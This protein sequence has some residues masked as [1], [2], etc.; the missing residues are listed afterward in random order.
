MNHLSHSEEK[1]KMTDIKTEF[2]KAKRALF[3]RIYR[4]LNK[5]QREAIYTVNGPLLVLAGAGSG[6]TTVLVRRISHLIKYGNAYYDDR[7]NQGSESE[8]DI[9]NS[10][11]KFAETEDIENMLTAYAVSPV[12]PWNILAI[13]F[14]NKAA[15]E[16]KTRLATTLGDEE[17]ASQIWAGTFHS[18]CVRILRRFG[19]RLGYTQ[20]FTIYD[21]D[22]VKKLIGSTMK[23]LNIS[24]KVLPVRSVMNEISRA[25]DELITPD[26]YNLKVG[27]DYRLLQISKIYT[28]YQT[29][30]KDA[31]AVDFDDII[32]QTVRLLEENS[33]VLDY[34]QN[35]FR[36]VCVDE[37]QDTNKAQF[38]LTSLLSGKYRNIMVVG[39]DDQSIYKFRGATIENILNF[40]KEYGEAKVIKLEQNY[41]STQTILDAANAV[42]R[43]NAGRKGKEL[44]TDGKKGEKILLRE[45]A[46]QNEEA[47]HIV[48]T[49]SEQVQSGLRQ[50]KDFVVLY[51]MNAQ[52]NSLESAFARGGVPYRVLGGTR[53]YDRK[54]IRDILAYL[55]IIK[56]PDDNL[57]LKRII[58]EPKRKIGDSTV[59][60]IEQLAM[61][62]GKSMFEIMR[63][64]S[65]FVSISRSADRLVAFVKM[66]DQLRELS[67]ELPINELITKTAEVSGYKDMLISEGNEGLDRISNI[68]ELSSSAVEY[69]ENYA[70]E[71]EA[72]LSG[73]LETV[74]LVSDVD[75]YDDTADAV[76]MM[77]IHSAKGL[78]FPVVFLPG[79]EENIFPGIQSQSDDAELEEERRLAYVAITRAKEQLYISHV[80]QR[81]LFGRTQMNPVSRF[82]EEIPAELINKAELPR[83]TVD[84]AAAS[85][86]AR[87]TKESAV[88]RFER[89]INSSDAVASVNRK[90]NTVARE[91]FSVGD[92]VKHLKFGCGEILSASNMGGDIM[93]EIAFDDFGT[94]K[95]M[96]SYAKLKRA[97]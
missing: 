4:K 21:T 80:S 3:D 16:I 30:L 56:N 87:D 43:N 89:Q 91:E 57:R 79:M 22:D 42:I 84:Y 37:Y 24:D 70:D 45:L 49:V 90:I 25:K 41:R 92:R 50:Y 67:E 86:F 60:A 34:Y 96:A 61:S 15:N 68:E 47:R 12:A 18:I 58:N 73:F 55:C 59:N 9:F 74:A 29:A 23:S 77:T 7:I 83:K 27:N 75:K 36:Y 66:I 1:N 32:V 52:A 94:K 81:L 35:K 93:Y 85:S 13:T 76:V 51:R 5:D 69:A 71:G 46:D 17:T 78:E 72:T 28:Q 39:D 82:A 62:E 64:S 88:L 14:T 40:D 54:E 6:K 33:D 11:L 26:D 63:I 48:S 2:L 20:D 8:L 97:E 65:Q 19:D 53:F 10:A 44:W 95:L 31:N 38:M